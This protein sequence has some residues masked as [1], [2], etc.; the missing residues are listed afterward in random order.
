MTGEHTILIIDDSEDDRDVYLRLLRDEPN[1]KEIR[2]AE[3]GREGIAAFKAVPADCILLDYRMPGEDGLSVLEEIKSLDAQDT[4]VIVLTGQGNEEIAVAAMKK[5]ASDYVVKDTISAIGLRRA[6]TNAIEKASLQKKIVKQ[7]EEQEIFLRTLIH[8]A[9]APLRHISTFTKLL[10]EDIR[11]EDYDDV[12]EHGEAISLSAMRIQDLIDTLA[13]YALSE[14]DV[15]FEQVAM[16]DVIEAALGSLTQVIADRDAHVTHTALPSVT[17]HRPQLIQL[18]QNLIGNGIKYCD[19]DTPEVVVSAS[20][21]DKGVW[22]F[23]VEDNGIGIPGDRLAFVFEPFKR[24]WSHDSYEGTGLGLAICRK[25]VER[26]GGEIWC[27]SKEG[28]GSRFLFT[29]GADPECLTVQDS[30]TSSLSK[31]V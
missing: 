17:G 16:D 3:T 15:A 2:T 8:D 7:Q 30:A 1:I 5:G 24:L 21:N 6:V 20:R 29:L 4:P 12:L 25:I 9:R 31:A 26:H 13:A 28:E 18:L 11:A 10:A 19:A 22:Q 14:G 23:Q 27:R